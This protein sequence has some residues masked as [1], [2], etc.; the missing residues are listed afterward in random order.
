MRDFSRRSSLSRYVS[1]RV[2]SAVT[3]GWISERSVDCAV[4]RSCSE[5]SSK[6]CI[7]SQSTIADIN[8]IEDAYP[9]CLQHFRQTW[10]VAHT[11][12]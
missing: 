4:V 5:T 8:N 9:S 12:V 2:S 1:T 10:I 6:C 11:G 7:H 3:S